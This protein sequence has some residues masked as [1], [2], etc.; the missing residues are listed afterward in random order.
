MKPQIVSHMVSTVDGRLVTT[1][2]SQPFD[3]KSAD[4]VLDIYFQVAEKV[5]GEA[6]ILGRVTLQEFL[7]LK[8]FETTDHAPA[9]DLQTFITERKGKRIFIV[10]DP[11]GKVQYEESSEYDFIALLGET[12]SESYLAH[13]RERKVSYLFCGTE[14]QDLAKAMDIL[15]RDF[16]FTKLRLEG[17]GVVNGSFLKAGLLS[18]LSL[19]VY[20]GIDGL[21]GV[22]SIF[23]H[24]GKADEMP[25][26][27]QALELTSVQ[28][29]DDG[30]VWL[31][32]AFHK[33]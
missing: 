27:G 28:Q 7:S 18:E 31:R 32:Y 19:L 23:E 22:S 29:L 26:K 4:D 24:K 30:M 3:G 25:A 5:G 12:V 9:R 11:R 15:G 14:G 2:Y 10:T 16:G 8:D 1:R 21:S 20:P 33:I 17:G 13:L 6:T